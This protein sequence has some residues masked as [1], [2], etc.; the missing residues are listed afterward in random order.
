MYN[1]ILYS[2]INNSCVINLY[3]CTESRWL[4][5]Q[6]C[7]NFKNFFNAILK[8]FEGALLENQNFKKICKEKKCDII[9]DY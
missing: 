7:N 1:F 6:N 2:S 4:Y 8:F 9:S 3:I 5:P